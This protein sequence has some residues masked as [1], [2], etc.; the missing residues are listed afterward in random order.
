MDNYAHY[1]KFHKMTMSYGEAEKY[2][3]VGWSLKSVRKVLL[4]G[5]N[6]EY[7]E[8]VLAWEKDGDPII[9]ENLD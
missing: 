7:E 2:M 6:K 4:R 5:I 1:H 3:N 8:C 9:P